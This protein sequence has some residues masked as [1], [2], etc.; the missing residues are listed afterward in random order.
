MQFS[1]RPKQ[2][3]TVMKIVISSSDGKI[4]LLKP[5]PRKLILT[6]GPMTS[7]K[8]QDLTRDS[9]KKLYATAIDSLISSIPE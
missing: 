6:R 9:S 1:T 8:A 7:K 2:S 4:H 3:K 5:S